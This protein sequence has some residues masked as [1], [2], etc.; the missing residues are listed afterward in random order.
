MDIQATCQIYR[1]SCCS[2]TTISRKLLKLQRKRHKVSLNLSWWAPL[3]FYPPHVG[4]QNK[5]STLIDVV[6]SLGEYIND[7]DLIL[8][9]KAVSYLTAVIKALPNT[10]LT[11]QQIG[12]LTSFYCDRI[13]DGGAI[14]GLDRLQGLSR[15]NK[16]LVAMIARA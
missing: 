4:L 5:Q 7:E 16:E 9:G 1:P 13:A 8:R 11:R 6:Q 2:L 15:F 14:A 3:M 12:V 10:F